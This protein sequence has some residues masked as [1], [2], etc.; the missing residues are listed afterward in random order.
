[1]LGKSLSIN[2]QNKEWLRL[3]KQYERESHFPPLPSP[4]GNSG[5]VFRAQEGRAPQVISGPWPESLGT[6]NSHSTRN[7]PSDDDNNNNSIDHT[8]VPLWFA[9]FS[10]MQLVIT[11]CVQK[12]SHLLGRS[13]VASLCHWCIYWFIQEKW[14]RISYH[15]VK[16]RELD[17]WSLQR[18]GKPCS[19]R[20]QLCFFCVSI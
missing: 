20:Y 11:L 6:K 7:C 3:S 2:V 17:K 8:D 5:T 14:T 4:R 18:G 16:R 12:K 15:W 19:L 13:E 9:K 1:M 10:K